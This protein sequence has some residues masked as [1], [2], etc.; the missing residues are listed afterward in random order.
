MRFYFKSTDDIE[1]LQLVQQ[2]KPFLSAYGNT[3]R[4]WA[5]VA[6]NFSKDERKVT[7]KHVEIY[8][9]I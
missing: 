4:A 5:E 6:T 9:Y 2:F 3:N 8:F 1:L 7:G